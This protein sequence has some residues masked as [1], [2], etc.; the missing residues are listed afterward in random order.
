MNLVFLILGG[1]FFLIGLVGL[2]LPVIPQILVKN[3]EDF[4]WC[5]AGLAE[6]E[7]LAE[8]AELAEM[9]RMADA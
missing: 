6:M 5:A 7:E 3:G 2:M 4:L 1:L 8:L 9:D